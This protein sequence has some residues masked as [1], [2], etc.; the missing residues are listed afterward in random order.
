MRMFFTELLAHKVPPVAVTFWVVKF[1]TTALGEA[2]SD[3][4]V[5]TWNPYL[6]VIVAGVLFV[7]VL[8]WQITATRY[9]VWTYWCA[10]T[11]V[12]IFGTVAADVLHV[13]FGVPYLVS[14]VAFLV[15]LGLVFVG[16]W[17]TER[18][19]SFH[20][21]TARRRELWYWAAVSA[22]FALGTATGDLTAWSFGLG[23]LHS[24]LLFVV[25]ILIPLLVHPVRP[26][27][28]PVAVFWVAYILTR[29]FGASFAD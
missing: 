23:Y 14:S 28:A 21:I 5:S 10:V 11:M 7:A 20:R 3:A 2:T 16:W 13:Q 29:P 24:A 15:V 8:M 25:L 6:V 19:L 12:A 4:F 26:Q 22:T 1:L 27:L 9:R 17:A 18:T